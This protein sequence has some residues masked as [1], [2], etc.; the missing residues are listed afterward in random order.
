MKVKRLA[1]VGIDSK[2]MAVVGRRA[3]GT[4]RGETVDDVEAGR[5]ASGSLEAGDM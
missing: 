4:A 5:V 2:V 1:T 3:P